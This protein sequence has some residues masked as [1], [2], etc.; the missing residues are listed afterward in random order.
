MTNPYYM[1]YNNSSRPSKQMYPGA[2]P[3]QNANYN[4][5]HS[6]SNLNADIKTNNTLNTKYEK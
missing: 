1:Q 5:N 3:N 2:R 6:M 4:P